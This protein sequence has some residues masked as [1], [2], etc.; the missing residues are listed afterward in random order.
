[1]HKNIKGRKFSRK[2][3]PRKAL[4]KSLTRALI[5]HERIETTEAKGKELSRIVEKLVTKAKKGD[6]AARREVAMYLDDQTA[7]K[8]THE[9]A[10]RYKERPGGYIRITKLGP[11]TSDSA[12]MSVVEFV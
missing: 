3:G 7:H 4:F 12:K 2:A 10:D 5:L 8:I 11:R 1:M 9:L 6:L